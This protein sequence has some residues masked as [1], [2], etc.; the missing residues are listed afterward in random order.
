MN[1]TNRT[2]TTG[3][4]ISLDAD[5]LAS[6]VIADFNGGS[7]HKRV[8]PSDVNEMLQSVFV[9]NKS[10]G[11][12]FLDGPFADSSK[13]IFE[14]TGIER[15]GGD[16]GDHHGRADEISA[17]G[18]WS[19]YGKGNGSYTAEIP[20]QILKET[21]TG[22]EV[23]T[24]ARGN[25]SYALRLSGSV[26]QRQAF[27]I[28][29]FGFELQCLNGMAGTFDLF[30]ESHRQ[31][32]NIN[33]RQ[34]LITGLGKA[35]QEY[36]KLDNGITQLLNTY[37]TE[38]QL[39]KFFIS[40]VKTDTINGGNLNEIR[41]YFF[42]VSNPWFRDKEMNAYRLMN[43]CTLYGER[44]KSADVKKKIQS[45][46][47]WPLSDAGLFDLPEGCKYP[48]TF[49]DFS[50]LLSQTKNDSGFEVDDRQTEILDASY[51]VLS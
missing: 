49:N 40:A 8:T 35:S 12:A 18:K 11:L 9:E 14:P 43:A 21:P 39:N 1:N 37:P 19:H 42:D 32:K 27:E 2:R 31:T 26:D 7:R 44:Q 24:L 36:Q 30:K 28:S 29:V 6:K 3:T 16:S 15:N 45:R 47:Y 17:F 23:Q 5:S 25:G 10:G 20:V 4:E 13:I 41:D 22:R 51:Q 48:S 50:S 46:I 38:S 33:I 34:M